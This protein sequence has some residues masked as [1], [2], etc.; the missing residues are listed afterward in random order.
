M[1]NQFRGYI[2]YTEEDYKNIQKNAFIIID[3]NVILNFYRYSDQTRNT[4]WT[5]L[6]HLKNRILVSKTKWN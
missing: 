1:K 4:M 6:E 2:P 5:I 3:T